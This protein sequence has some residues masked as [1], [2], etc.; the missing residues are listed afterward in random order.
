[1]LTSHHVF[2][3]PLKVEFTLFKKTGTSR[4]NLLE[5]HNE[6]CLADV[7]VWHCLWALADDVES[8]SKKSERVVV[9]KV[10]FFLGLVIF[11]SGF[12]SDGSGVPETKPLIVNYTVSVPIRAQAVHAC[13]NRQGKN[14]RHRGRHTQSVCMEPHPLQHNRER[15]TSSFTSLYSLVDQRLPTAITRKVSQTNNTLITR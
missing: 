12:L 6:L 10:S 3:G 11:C 1:M 2:T 9:F 7:L 15:M 8:F 5:N 13:G 4:L 14:S